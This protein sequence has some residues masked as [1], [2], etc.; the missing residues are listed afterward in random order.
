MA[1]ER[2]STVWMVN[3]LTGQS[4]RK[5]LLSLGNGS[6]MFDPESPRV[7]QSVFPVSDIKRARRVRGSPVL[8]IALSKGGS[9][10]RMGFY[11]V[12]PPSLEAEPDMMFFRTK[13]IRK[14]AL[15]TLRGAN[16]EKKPEIEEWVRAIEAARGP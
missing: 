1:D 6:L 5:G 15:N 7:G 13:R 12:R 16:K 4:G 8:E 11:F 3:A 9:V 14:R 2:R 10:Q